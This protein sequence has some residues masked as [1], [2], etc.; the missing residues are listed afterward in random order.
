MK[1]FVGKRVDVRKSYQII[2]L[3]VY[4]EVSSKVDEGKAV[5][6]AVVKVAVMSLLL[7]V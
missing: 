4:R 3:T 6:I 5:V 1:Q 2:L 7:L